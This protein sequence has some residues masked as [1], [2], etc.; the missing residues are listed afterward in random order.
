[1]KGATNTNKFTPE[2]NWENFLKSWD[3]QSSGQE[4]GYWPFEKKP[5][6]LEKKLPTR[7]EFTV[8]KHEDYKEKYIIPRE[9]KALIEQ[10]R[11]EIEA[12]KKAN[13]GV[14]EE[15]ERVEKVIIQMRPE[16]PGVYHI[17]FLEMILRFLRA[18]RAKVGEAKTWLAAMITKKKKRG[19]LFLHLTKKKGTQYSLSNELQLTRAVQ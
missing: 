18:F 10:I 13:Q 8:F 2:K 16:K 11:K 17:N 4:I 6:H 12:I 9:I 14:V 15:V 7:L 5:S 1:M 19:S 3:G